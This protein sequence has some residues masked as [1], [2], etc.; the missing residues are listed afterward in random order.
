MT[1]VSEL[2]SMVSLMQI[3]TKLKAHFGN[4]LSSRLHSV[5]YTLWFQ[6]MDASFWVSDLAILIYFSAKLDTYCTSLII[7]VLYKGVISP[8]Q[9]FYRKGILVRSGSWI[10]VEP[11]FYFL[12][13][14]FSERA[15]A[16]LKQMCLFR[17]KR[18]LYTHQNLEDLGV[19]PFRLGKGVLD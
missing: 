15:S 13:Q 11:N 6:D 12:G 1:I 8:N 2:N 4:L 5:Q 7:Q 19:I 18:E 17:F 10:E 14:I 3:N 9:F 16:Q